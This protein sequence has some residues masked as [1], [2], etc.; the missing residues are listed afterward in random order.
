MS[1]ADDAGGS[2]KASLPR[3]VRTI[4]PFP[5][6]F[7]KLTFRACGLGGVSVYPPLARRRAVRRA[8]RR[9]L[10]SGF[11]SFGFRVCGKAEKPG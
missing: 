5:N 1:P 7:V 10:R 9:G 4:C 6:E 2:W 3:L 11:G 8:R